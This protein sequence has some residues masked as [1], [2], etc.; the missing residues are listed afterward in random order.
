MRAWDGARWGCRETRKRAHEHEI[1]EL[2]GSIHAARMLP[3][4]CN[5]YTAR[6]TYTPMLPITIRFNLISHTGATNRSY[7]S[8]NTRCNSSNIASRKAALYIALAVAMNSR[9]SA[10][11]ISNECNKKIHSNG[12]CSSGWALAYVSSLNLW[13]NHCRISNYNAKDF[14]KPQLQRTDNVDRKTSAAYNLKHIRV[15]IPEA[16]CRPFSFAYSLC[17]CCV[18]V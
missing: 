9:S 17:D 1:E 15:L 7:S 18:C 13:Q 10:G 6:H 8:N 5:T 12:C 16:L 11:S 14:P 4:T 3:V 2:C